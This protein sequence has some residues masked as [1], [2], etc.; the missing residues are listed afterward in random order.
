MTLD[1]DAR[2]RQAWAG[3]AT[4]YENSFGKLCAHTVPALLDAAG[5][6]S[7]LR[8]LDVGTGPGTV[9]AAALARGAK[10]TAVDAEPDMLA[11]AASAAPGAE[12]RQAALP[13]L[14]F[15]EGEF[16][17]VVGNFVLNHVARPAAALTELRR[18]T[19]PGGRVVLTIW[20]APAAPGKA[21]LGRAFA[22]AGVLDRLDF[23]SLAAED[24]FRRDEPGFAGLLTSAGLT[25]ATCALLAW[26][27]LTTAEEWWSGPASGI[28]TLG[29][30]L[31]T[32]PPETVATVHAHFTTLAAAFTTSEGTLALPHTALLAAG[33]APS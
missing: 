29:Q 20:A 27:H 21:L 32:L 25:E 24:D 17:A 33:R 12:V 3:Q 26:D 13:E 16:D 28:A 18:V 2:E 1:F 19:R 23:P 8:V 4:A 9:A 15:A 5:P 11:R 14:P 10:V 30:A 22:A 6:L 7:G 31:R